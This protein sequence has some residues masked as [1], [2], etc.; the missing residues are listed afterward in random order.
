MLNTAGDEILPY[1]DPVGK[2][3]YFA[4]DGREGIGGFD[5]YRSHYDEERNEWSEPVSL[6]FPVNSAFDD[7]LLLPGTDLGMVTFFSARQTNDTAIAVYRVH[8]SEPKQSLASRSPQEIRRIANLDNAASEMM[9][10]FEAYKD[11]L[12]VEREETPA[13]LQTA[14]NEALTDA[15]SGSAAPAGASALPGR[16]HSGPLQSAD[17]GYQALISAALRHQ[18]ASDSLTELSTAARIRVRE[19]TDPNE[20]WL[21]QRQIM[22]WEKK[23]SE[24]QDLADGYFSQVADYN[25]PAASSVITH[26]TLKVER[27]EYKL[28]DNAPTEMT[29]PS[30]PDVAEKAKAVF[31]GAAH[32][33][34][35]QSGA[36]LPP[37][38]AGPQTGKMNS[39][40]VQQPVAA[41]DAGNEHSDGQLQTA[42]GS[43][44]GSSGSEEKFSVVTDG[45]SG[46]AI[47]ASGSG[48]TGQTVRPAA[49]PQAFE[50]LAAS[51]YSVSNPVPVD[52]PLPQGTLYRIQLGVFSGTVDPE[53]YG[54]LTPISAMTDPERNLVFYY[55]GNFKSYEAAMDALDIVRSQG[56]SDAFIVSWYNGA[57]MS[58]EKARK[59]E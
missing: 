42:S 44:K 18:A 33:E 3:L 48:N 46:S 58:V 38:D 37:K 29:V 50:L 12:A 8:L 17:P 55:A 26:D 59:L 7:Y 49:A 11:F 27:T 39:E 36:T 4:S 15:G 35:E 22:V 1:F 40:K 57:R 10:E 56:F 16:D 6:G 32:Q 13:S 51:P 30:G 53:V 19:S 9:K 54:G 52:D 23:S 41:R 47:D 20:K 5:L 34:N 24:E 45:M 14:H 31:S 28:V 25:K 43:E 21:S 2:D